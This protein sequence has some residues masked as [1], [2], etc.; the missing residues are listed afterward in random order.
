MGI[1]ATFCSYTC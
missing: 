1:P